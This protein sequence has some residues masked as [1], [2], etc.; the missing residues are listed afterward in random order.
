[1]CQ[2]WIG[3]TV[4]RLLRECRGNAG[5]EFALVL[6][7]LMLLLFGAIEI[8]RALHDF[9]VV[10]ETVR[11]AGRYLSRIS[12]RCESAGDG[13]CQACSASGDCGNC[14]FGSYDTNGNFVPNSFVTVME[15][16]LS[17]ISSS[18]V[19]SLKF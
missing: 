17:E 6:P 11:D 19:P 4:R 10:N 14:D 1:M 13:T 18:D 7:L 9:H 2:Y 12:Y 5:A 16:C 8:G 15:F 3:K